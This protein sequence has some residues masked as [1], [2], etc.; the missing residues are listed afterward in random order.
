MISF[1]A[2]FN[3]GCKV[4]KSEYHGLVSQFLAENQEW[5]IDGN[6][7]S[8]VGD[9]MYSAATDIIWL[10]PPALLYWPRLIRRTFWRLLRLNPAGD[11]PEGCYETIG[12]VFF[13]SNSIIW[14]MIKGHWRLRKRYARL[15][16]GDNAENGGKIRRI[17]G[18]GMQFRVWWAG[19]K[20]LAMG[21]PQLPTSTFV[22]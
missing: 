4:S 19:V 15:L 22:H 9:L 7:N 13:N 2:P 8:P 17:G 11:L 21:R 1:Y 6:S 12:N 3:Q 5:V 14:W 20:A 16:E 18:W 10:D